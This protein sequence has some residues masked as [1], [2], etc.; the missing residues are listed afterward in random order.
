VPS[1]AR[2]EAPLLRFALHDGRPATLLVGEA[3]TVL[4]IDDA[5]VSSWDPSGRPYALVRETGTYR[6]GLDGR[7]LWKRE[8]TADGPRLRRRLSASEGEAIVDAARREAEESLAVLGGPD[9]PGPEGSAI[10]G[11]GRAEAARRLRQIVA[12]DGA[13]LRDDSARFLAASGP[14]GILPPDQY[15]ALVVRVTE[16]CSWNACT[17]CRLYREVPFRWKSPGELLA[18]VEAL[19]AY[20]G[21]SIALRR[22]VFL[23][24]ANALCLAHDRLR[25]LVE[26]VARELS[27]APLFSFL[28][29]STGHRRTSAEWRDYA[30]LGLRRV[31]LGLETGDP[32][33]LAWLGK[34]GSPRDA[35]DLVASLHE[36]GIAVGVIVLLGA[37]GERFAAAH[38]QGTAEVLSAMCLGPDD[39]VYFSE[40]VD[41][42]GFA[43][44]RGDSGAPD[45]QPLSPARDAELRRAILDGLRPADP[46]RPPRFSTYDIRE[47][48]Y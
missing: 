32:D 7:L 39:L 36:A 26:L 14:V 23:G 48:V 15:L 8:T 5:L 38:A 35:V 22:S 27:G 3:A 17:F 45:L 1:S 24:D 34:P 6:R 44:G 30:A 33:L 43:Y 9:R 47:F 31:Y 42:P 4:S 25:P 40:Y 28:D 19:R 16:G 13:A 18:H 46:A 20:F 41:E 10:A 11:A 12:M 21:P 29:V 2:A 37:G